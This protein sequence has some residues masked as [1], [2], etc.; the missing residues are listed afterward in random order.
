MA[1][2][3]VSLKAIAKQIDKAEH[4]LELLART[5]SVKERTEIKED[6]RR[7]KVIRREVVLICKRFFLTFAR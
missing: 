1:T 3:R 2:R 4:K 5:A 7:L 6:I